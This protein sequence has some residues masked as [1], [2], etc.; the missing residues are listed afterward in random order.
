MPVNRRQ[1]F[2][3]QHYLRQFRVAGTDLIVVTRINPYTF[4]GE[5]PIKGQCQESYFYGKD[6]PTDALLAEAEAAIA[7]PTAEVGRTGQY[8]A[9]QL[10]HLRFLAITLYLRTRQASEDAKALPR[11]IASEFIEHGIKNGLLPAPPGEW[12]PEMMDFD[13]IPDLLITQFRSCYLESLSLECK[14]LVCSGGQLF[15]TSDNPAVALNQYAANEGSARGC[16]GFSQAGFQLIL[17]L[18]PRV[19]AFFYDGKTYKVGDRSAQAVNVTDSDVSLINSLQIQS[20]EH[21]IYSHSVGTQGEIRHLLH[22]YSR[23]RRDSAELVTKHPTNAPNEEL[24]MAS[25]RVP[26][27]PG[28]WAFCHYVRRRKRRVGERRDPATTEILKRLDDDFDNNPNG[29]DVADRLER[30]CRD[31]EIR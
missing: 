23:L 20:A 29:G 16:V 25:T 28:R 7:K 10:R 30:L 13:G 9:D 15:V 22:R 18:S 8:D 11:L 2:V 31:I 26:V 12:K 4:V 3:P 14:L 21:C 6:S 17:P 1:H 24:I 5:G 19:C 27:V